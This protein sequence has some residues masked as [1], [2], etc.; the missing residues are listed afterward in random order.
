MSHHKLLQAQ[1]RKSARADGSLDHNKFVGLIDSAYHDSDRERR[2]SER[3][4]DLM[5][6]EL[7]ELNANLESLASRRADELRG[8]RIAFDATLQ[9]TA[10]GIF[11]IDASGR[12]TSCNDRAIELLDLP[13]GMMDEH[14]HITALKNFLVERGEFETVDLSEHRWLEGDSLAGAPLLYERRRPN[15]VVLEVRT[16]TLANGGVVR[17]LTDVTEER[18]RL[19]ELRQ[20][21][22]MHRN[23]FEN[24][25]AG[26][27]RATITGRLLNANMALARIFGCESVEEFTVAFNSRERWKPF[28]EDW[29]PAFAQQLW[30]KGYVTDFVCEAIEVATGKRLGSCATPPERPFITKARLPTS[31]PARLPK[32][33][34]RIWRCT[35]L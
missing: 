15:G 21:E 26:L 25:A 13:R 30:A 11:V 22:R 27:Y 18:R 23:L 9:N 24:A 20:A 32:V 4:I 31:P 10:Q 33:D 6:R 16:V 19:E 7:G 34:W 8:V 2:R 3:S 17:T 1:L 5:V 14:P 12:V 35:T 28:G 29:R